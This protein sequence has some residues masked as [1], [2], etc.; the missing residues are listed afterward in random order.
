MASVVDL[1]KEVVEARI[2]QRNEAFREN[3]KLTE[4]IASLNEALADNN[5]FLNDLAREYQE[6]WT[7]NCM[8]EEILRKK[9]QKLDQFHTLEDHCRQ[10]KSQ[11]ETLRE[12][13]ATLKKINETLTSQVTVDRENQNNML[14]QF[15]LNVRDLVEENH[16]LKENLKVLDKNLAEAKNDFKNVCQRLAQTELHTGR[17]YK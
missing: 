14:K 2:E 10:L 3:A 16:R 13:I 17:K 1:L 7:Q 15:L 8:L 12:E 11:T 6:I 5:R 4:E 9:N